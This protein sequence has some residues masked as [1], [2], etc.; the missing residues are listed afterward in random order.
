MLLAGTCT[1]V[2]YKRFRGTPGPKPIT[3]GPIFPIHAG[4]NFVVT[5]GTGGLGMVTAELLA[6]E[7]AR[8]VLADRDPAAVEAT[9]EKLGGEAAGFLGVELDLLDWA[10]I[11]RAA[12]ASARLLGRIDGLANVA[13]VA[14][15]A[16]A[17][18]HTREM[19]D[20]HFGVNLFGTFELTRQI[21]L[22]MVEHGEGGA[23]VNV[24]SEAGKVGHADM[25]AYNASK[26][27]VVNISRVLALEWAPFG[28]N[29][30]CV[31]PGGIDTPMLRG[32]ADDLSKMSGQAADDIY[33]IMEIEQL[34][35]HVAPMEVAMTISFLLGNRV[36]AIRGVA[37]NVDGGG[38][39][40]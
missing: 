11:E 36:Q 2:E 6:S 40:Y 7:G 21:A 3:D 10:S 37:I 28:I 39:P 30:N 12:S 16:P 24:A 35:R 13:G 31:C 18:E 5:G 27:G 33:T 34:G 19:W 1:V 4:K 14:G 38:V 26:A 20:L 15:M 25:V 22:G 17:L 29:V 8:V 23:I 9:V 32:V